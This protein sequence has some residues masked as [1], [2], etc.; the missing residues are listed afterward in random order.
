MSQEKE[1]GNAENSKNKR[2]NYR[3]KRLRL[4]M[5]GFRTALS[6]VRGLRSVRTMLYVRTILLVVCVGRLGQD[7][8]G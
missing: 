3:W 8:V 5:G 1:K 7:G 2:F 6:N 4:N